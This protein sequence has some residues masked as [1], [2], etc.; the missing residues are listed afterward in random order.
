MKNLFLAA[1]I[2]TSATAFSATAAKATLEVVDAM[3]LAKPA[4]VQKFNASGNRTISV[5]KSVVNGEDVYTLL[6]QFCSTNG[7]SPS[8]CLGGAQLTIKIKV[9]QRMSN[10]VKV[11]ESSVV[12]IR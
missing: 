9:E 5:T 12:G 4:D 6:R 11:G 7:T 2:L 8:Q 10:L 3:A 1:M